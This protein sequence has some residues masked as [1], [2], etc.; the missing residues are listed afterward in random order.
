MNRDSLWV[1]LDHC[2]NLPPKLLCILCAL[3]TDSKA[4]VRTYGMTS[5]EIPVTCGVRQG[6]VLAPTLFNLYF[7]VAIRLALSEHKG[8]R[9][10]FACLHNTHHVSNHKIMCEE[11]IVLDL[12]YE[13][14]MALLSDNWEDL[15]AMLSSL[16][17][18]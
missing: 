3:Y 15:T 16:A 13:D 1:L 2:Y 18:H 10:K 4:A 9:V 14:D 8:K 12:E 17:A 5:K 6:C 7:D 11:S